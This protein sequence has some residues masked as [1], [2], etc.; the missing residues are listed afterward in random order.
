MWN[1]FHIHIYI[2]RVIFVFFVTVSADHWKRWVIYIYV[3]MWMYTY[4][5]IWLK[6]EKLMRL[7]NLVFLGFHSEKHKCRFGLDC[8]GFEKWSTKSKKGLKDSCEKGSYKRQPK[9][10]VCWC[11]DIGLIFASELTNQLL[12]TMNFYIWLKLT[13]RQE[14]YEK[15]EKMLK[16]QK[17]ISF[18][19]ITTYK[20]IYIYK[21][22]YLLK[23]LILFE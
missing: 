22:I 17:M 20:Y 15:G 12:P 14:Q 13:F 19:C 9:Y 5:Y 23:K 16:S 7:R 4:I 2:Y 21:C 3:C 1:F 18:P 11:W 10:L 8:N 6:L